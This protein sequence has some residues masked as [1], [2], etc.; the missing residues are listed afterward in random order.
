MLRPERLLLS[1]TKSD[2]GLPVTVSDITFL[3]NNVHVATKTR[4]GN[5]LSV[6]L[7]FGHERSPDSIGEMP[8]GSD[9]MPGRRT[10]SVSEIAAISVRRRAME[11]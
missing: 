6:R 4:K 2:I 5:D 8:F 11:Q 1:K 3:G 10:F 9:S 7:P